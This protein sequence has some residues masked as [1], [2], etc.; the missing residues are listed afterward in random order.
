M[1]KIMI[2]ASDRKL[3]ALMQEDAR[4]THGE[5][6]E[7]AGLSQSASHRRVRRLEESGVI[8]GYRA[9]IDRR[10]VGLNVLAYVFV[11]LESHAPELLEAFTRGVEQIDEIV[12][13]YA[14]AGGGDYLLKVVAA[15]MD[16]YADLALKKIVRLPGVKDSESNFVLSTMKPETGWP[17][18]G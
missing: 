15:D 10:R 1:G 4:L 6:A 8:A 5:L 3:I 18:P 13:C 2:D 11:K 9:T 17:I 16:A 12:A 7:R 14:I